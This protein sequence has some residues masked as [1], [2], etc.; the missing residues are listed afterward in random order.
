MRR[1]R[2]IE[3]LMLVLL[4]WVSA[5]ATFIFWPE[6]QQR[7]GSDSERVETK[8]DSVGQTISSKSVFE[9]NAQ[10]SGTSFRTTAYAKSPYLVARRRVDAPKGNHSANRQRAVISAP[11]A[12]DWSGPPVQ[13]SE[14]QLAAHPPK[15]GQ[16]E[17]R[18][19]AGVWMFWRPESA[20]LGLGSAGQL[21]GSQAGGRLVVPVQDDTVRLSLRASTSFGETRSRE[22]A[23][24]IS[25]KPLANVPVELIVER[26]IRA[27]ANARDA[28]AAFAAG[29]VSHEHLADGWT[30]DAY[31]QGGVV[32]TRTRDWF[33]DGAAAARRVVA[34]NVRIGAG[35][36]G[37]VQ[38]GLKRLDIGPS[39]ST[40]IAPGDM[41][42]RL[43]VDWRVR[44]AGSARPGSGVAVTIAKD[45]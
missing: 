36:W 21:G 38:P 1:A 11:T 30:L 31:A 4:L 43:D 24:G 33:A 35:I 10:P 2:S 32:G 44:I 12:N 9:K 40:R 45:F 28:T 15:A 16:T 14:A 20:G 22:L 6:Q 42:L 13:R 29:G 5:R 37:G 7:Y 23:P 41:A 27:G 39:L 18:P 17:W 8:R 26:R 3:T 19:T 25:L 34:E